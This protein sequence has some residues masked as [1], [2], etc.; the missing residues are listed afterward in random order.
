MAL[1]NPGA[2]YDGE[3]RHGKYEGLGRLV[4][5]GET[6]DGGFRKGKKH[7]PGV[8]NTA[9]GTKWKGIFANDEMVQG[10][11]TFVDGRKFEGVFAH[12]KLVH[13]VV[14]DL[15]G[16]HYSGQWLDGLPHGNGTKIFP[17]GARYE[18]DFRKG[19]MSGPGKIF[20]PDG[21]V[22]EGDY[23]DRA[24]TEFRSET[25]PYGIFN[26]DGLFR[27]GNGK[28][29]R[30]ILRRVREQSKS[31]RGLQKGNVPPRRPGEK[32]LSQGF[33]EGHMPGF[34]KK[35]TEDGFLYVVDEG[36]S[37]GSDKSVS[38]EETNNQKAESPRVTAEATS[39]RDGRFSRMV[40]SAK[41]LRRNLM[42]SRG[43]TLRDN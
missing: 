22:Y 31:L 7:G 1:Q 43:R 16:S 28:E 5:K 19:L 10:T 23:M 38:G 34:S 41:S 32:V 35:F 8:M 3:W 17:D 9:D 15:D 21:S 37:S 29:G 13:G 36:E 18:G 20:K 4:Q 39:G 33:R 12:K 26:Y 25:S 30:R 27:G 42:L 40:G 2:F 6:Y 24:I 14:T 11:K